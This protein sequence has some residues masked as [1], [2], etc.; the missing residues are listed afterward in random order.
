V[1]TEEEAD[2]AVQLFDQAL[3][4]AARTR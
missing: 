3:T 1:L 2:V 4:D